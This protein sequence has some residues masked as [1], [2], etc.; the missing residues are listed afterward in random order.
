MLIF[1]TAH[2]RGRN[3]CVNVGTFIPFVAVD[4]VSGGLYRMIN[5]GA[6]LPSCGFE[7]FI[8]FKEGSLAEVSSLACPRVA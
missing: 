4:V 2:R 3:N 5:A 6:P 8:M 1:A 7:R